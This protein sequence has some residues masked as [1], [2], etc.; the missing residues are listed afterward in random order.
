MIRPVFAYRDTVSISPLSMERVV[1]SAKDSSAEIWR[2][3]ADDV[4]VEKV[5]ADR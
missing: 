5:D 1:T 2:D 4:A 3:V